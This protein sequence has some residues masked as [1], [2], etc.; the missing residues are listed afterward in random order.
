MH[1]FSK[2]W[3]LLFIAIQ[4]LI[5]LDTSTFVCSQL[6]KKAVCLLYYH[7]LFPLHKPQF[8]ANISNCI[9]HNWYCICIFFAFVDAAD[10]YLSFGSVFLECFCV[11]YIMD[12]SLT[13]VCQLLAG[14]RVSSNLF[15]L[16]LPVVS[17]NFSALSLDKDDWKNVCCTK[18]WKSILVYHIFCFSDQKSEPTNYP[19][20]N[21]NSC[22]MLILLSWLSATLKRS[23]HL[24]A[25]KIW[26]LCSIPQRRRS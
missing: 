11:H 16:V 2:Y 3:R 5:F 7:R 1:I 25:P 15:P 26:F 13:V 10:L 22:T 6:V 19:I 9:V 12:L 24:L 21:N 14:T 20:K 17:L 23:S 4:I 18:P 8:N